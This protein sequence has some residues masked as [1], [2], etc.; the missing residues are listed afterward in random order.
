MSVFSPDAFGKRR[1]DVIGAGATGS[2][3][4]LSLAKLGI[5]NLHV[6]DFDQIEEHNIANQ[7]YGLGDVGA[8]K[9]EALQSI[10]EADTRTVIE[11]YPERVDGSQG[12][13]EIV[14]LLPDTM[15][16]RKEIW[17]K[18]IKFKLRTHLMIET[19]MGAD[20]GRIY[21]INPSKPSHITEWEKTLYGDDE[22]EVSACG[23]PVTVGPT[24]E[25]ISGLA[26]WQL[27]K[28]FAIEQ[29]KEVSLDNEII[30]SLQ[31]MVILTRN[32]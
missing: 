18:A 6:W 24:A 21:T 23:A 5:T 20:T 19:R 16:A 14:F 1:V 8:L 9:V 7:V 22:A 31:P 12:F 32:F 27:I 13:G 26:V 15:A 4:V 2:R 25:I 17:E 3:I 28:W 10:V 30:F 29:G 11:I